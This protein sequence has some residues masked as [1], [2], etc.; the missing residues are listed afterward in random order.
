[1][2]STPWQ[3]NID[4]KTQAPLAAYSSTAA[5]LSAPCITNPHIAIDGGAF[6]LWA[7]LEAQ[8]VALYTYPRGWK[9]CKADVDKYQERRAPED[10]HIPFRKH[11]QL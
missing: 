4:R 3:N 1:M 9:V 11:A 7:E 8:L 10:P 5:P 2:R 6:P